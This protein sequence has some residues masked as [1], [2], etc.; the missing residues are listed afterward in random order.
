MLP[1]HKSPDTQEFVFYFVRHGETDWNREGKIQGQTDIPLNQLGRLQGEELKKKLDGIDFPYCFSSDLQRAS[2]TAHI[3]MKGRQ[4]KIVLD[5][6]LRER[7]FQGLEGKP[8]DAYINASLQ[9]RTKI[10]SDVALSDR[11]F[12]FLDEAVKTCSQ[13]NILIVTHGGVMR[14]ILSKI[15]SLTC[16]DTD[17]HVGNMATLKLLF[18]N[19]HWEIQ[20]SLE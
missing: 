4:A 10:E 2:E 14:S 6:R 19:G 9:D 1:K 16:R 5:K 13:G 20:Q 17:I 3:I 15:L 18:A 8:N 7:N 11:V 12:Q